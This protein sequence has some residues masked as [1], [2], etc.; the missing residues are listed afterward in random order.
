MILKDELGV[1][2]E[3]L[4]KKRRS[5]SARSIKRISRSGNTTEGSSQHHFKGK[6]QDTPNFLLTGE[7]P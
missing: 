4:L 6:G 1:A 2:L 5:F 3:G 7:K